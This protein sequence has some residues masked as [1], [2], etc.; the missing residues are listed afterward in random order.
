VKQHEFNIP[1]I[2]HHGYDE[3]NVDYHTVRFINIPLAVIVALAS[4]CHDFASNRFATIIQHSA[5][6]H[7]K[8]TRKK[9]KQFFDIFVHNDPNPH[10][11]MRMHL[12]AQVYALLHNA[13][14]KAMHDAVHTSH[15]AIIRHHYTQYIKA[16]IQSNLING[17]CAKNPDTVENDNIAFLF[18]GYCPPV[19]QLCY[20]NVNETLQKILSPTSSPTPESDESE[21]A[22]SEHP[23]N[24]SDGHF[25]DHYDLYHCPPD[26]DPYDDTNPCNLDDQLD[27]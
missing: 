12:L 27:F 23:E 17:Q 18:F 16:R 10:I 2:D 19:P 5:A 20:E 1:I 7:S 24:E 11:L 21:H 6:Q 22:P 15:H 3:F 13:D 26:L 4:I 14:E 9:F 8:P 25:D